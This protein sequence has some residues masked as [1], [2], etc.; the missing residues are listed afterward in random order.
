[1]FAMLCQQGGATSRVARMR[2][3]GAEF[4]RKVRITTA[5]TTGTSLHAGGPGRR[6][7]P[8]TSFSYTFAAMAFAQAAIATGNDEHA[9]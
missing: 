5:T 3:Q 2:V 8:T 7:S 4:L 6:S 1:M 9:T